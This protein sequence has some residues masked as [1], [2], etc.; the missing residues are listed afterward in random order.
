MSKELDIFQYDS[1]YTINYYDN[2]V[3]RYRW[4]KEVDKRLLNDRS[5]LES[6]LDEISGF[7]PSDSNRPFDFYSSHHLRNQLLTDGYNI[8]D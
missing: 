8:L 2:I 7:R 4:A 1:L 5:V 3:Y 6:S